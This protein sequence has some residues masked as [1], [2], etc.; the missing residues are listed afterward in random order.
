MNGVVQNSADKPRSSQSRD[1]N[2][3]PKTRTNDNGRNNRPVT[4]DQKD[5]SDKK[6]TN[7]QRVERAESKRMNSD[8][9]NSKYTAEGRTS[10]TNE[11][12]KDTRPVYSESGNHDRPRQGFN[13][14]NDDRHNSRTERS[15]RTEKPLLRTQV[16]EL[17]GAVLSGLKIV[18]LKYNHACQSFLFHIAALGSLLFW[19]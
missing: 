17:I 14:A 18:P 16:N 12:E 13:Q 5:G 15:E 7:H 2:A 19:F 3:P 4:Q 9:T 10:L 8:K 11:R 1:A 6:F